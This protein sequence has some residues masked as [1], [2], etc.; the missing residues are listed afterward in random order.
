[1]GTEKSPFGRQLRIARYPVQS[2]GPFSV[3]GAILVSHKLRAKPIMF[4]PSGTSSWAR[5]TGFVYLMYFL[6]AVAGQAL[7]SRGLVLPGKAVSFISVLLY[8]VLGILLY[9]L[10]RPAGS[11]LSLLAALFN[12]A[13][14]A[15]TLMPYLRDSKGPINPLLFFGMYCLLIGILILRSSFLPHILGLLN[16]AAGI[17]WFVFLV[18]LHIH[19]LTVL[20]EIFAEAAL[21]LWLLVKGVEEQRWAAQTAGG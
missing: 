14:S 11:I 9:R 13:G 1:M 6:M 18:P 20:L 12:F 10:L 16:A 8:I 7:L 17:G 5:A 21:M 15:A 3:L 2:L 19:S 4:I